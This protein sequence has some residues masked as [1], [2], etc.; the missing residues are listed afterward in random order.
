ML[1]ELKKDVLE[2]N[3]RLVETNLVVLTWG[4]VSGYDEESKLVAIKPSGVSYSKMKAEDIV[5]LDLEGNVV[6]GDLNPSSDT[7]THLEIYKNFADKG[8]RGI[9]HTHSVE[10]TAWAQA[11]REIPCY[12]TTHADQAYGPIPCSRVL[13]KEEVEEAYEKNTGKVIVECFKDKDP[14][15]Q[16]GILVA[17]HAPFTWGKTTKAAVDNSIA[18]ENIARM[19]RLTEMI[20]GEK[21]ELESYVADKHYFRK[22]GENAYY[23]QDN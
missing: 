10:A 6:E 15:A 18:L 11:K 17:G 21:K 14:L 3:L 20:S 23:G 16:P 7:P 22:H 13:T 8:V 9:V 2:Q 12:G 19:A 4:N 5:I 1:E